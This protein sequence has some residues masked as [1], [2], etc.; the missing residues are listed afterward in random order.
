MSKEELKTEINIL[1][2]STDETVLNEIL[3]YLKSVKE[4]PSR[5]FKLSKDLKT[6]LSEDAK[7]LERLAK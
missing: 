5:S 4:N 2:D 3:S 7:L 6:I 1:L